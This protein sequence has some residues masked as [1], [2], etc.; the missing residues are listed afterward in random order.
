MRRSVLSNRGIRRSKS[1]CKGMRAKWATMRT[2]P[3]TT[4]HRVEAGTQT[5]DDGKLERIVRLTEELDRVAGAARIKR[6][7]AEIAR[8][9][10]DSHQSA[11][12]TKLSEALG[13]IDE[14]VGEKW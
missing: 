2:P 11:L 10:L 14:L 8:Q 7:A 9:H 13:L 5:E 3:K 6:K 4:D 12:T 1:R